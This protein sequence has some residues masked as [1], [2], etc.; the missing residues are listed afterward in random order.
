MRERV[1]HRGVVLE[2][3][4]RNLVDHHEEAAAAAIAVV[5][6]AAVIVST[7]ISMKAKP[8]QGNRKFNIQER[9]I[10]EAVVVDHTVLADHTVLDLVAVDAAADRTEVAAVVAAVRMWGVAVAAH[11]EAAVDRREAVAVVAAGH[12]EVAVAVV[13]KAAVAAAAGVVDFHIVAVAAGR[14]VVVV[15]DHKVV[16]VAAVDHMEADVVVAHKEVV[17]DHT[18]VAARTVAAAA[19]EDIREA[20]VAVDIVQAVP[21]AG[22][23]LAEAVRHHAVPEEA[24]DRSC[25]RPAAEAD[26]PAGSTHREA[27]A[28][29]P[30]LVR[31]VVVDSYR[32]V[33]K[34]SRSLAWNESTDRPTAGYRLG[35]RAR[36]C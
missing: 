8:S 33:K 7:V 22:I 2:H 10:P 3:H 1:G 35:S 5:D 29:P 4:S 25:S 34:S 32:D 30:G 21:E 24:V 28:G 6:L 14:R 11:T 19:V 23:V 17:A 12:K 27:V 15:A 26:L 16:A 20:A 9:H 36:D 13:R 31:K 18:E